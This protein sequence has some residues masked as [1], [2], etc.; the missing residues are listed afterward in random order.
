MGIVTKGAAA[1]VASSHLVARQTR[2]SI[3]VAMLE[4]TIFLL[5]PCKYHSYHA[6]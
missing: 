1:P 5:G 3:T 4:T 2:V 6:D